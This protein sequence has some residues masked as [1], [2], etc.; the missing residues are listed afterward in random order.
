[1]T[2]FF[3]LPLHGA[4]SVTFFCIAQKKV[5]KE[6]SLQAGEFTELSPVVAA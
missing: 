3:F 4:A 6:P 2:L 5:T 1:L